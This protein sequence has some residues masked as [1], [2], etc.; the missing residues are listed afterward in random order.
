VFSIGQARQARH[1]E[2]LTMPPLINVFSIGQAR[3]GERVRFANPARAGNGRGV[4]ICEYVCVCVCVCVCVI[5]VYIGARE[6]G[7]DTSKK[8]KRCVY[9][10]VFEIYI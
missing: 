3:H 4:Y 8:P 9:V 7:V 10:F 1:G 5:H 2:P 6:Q